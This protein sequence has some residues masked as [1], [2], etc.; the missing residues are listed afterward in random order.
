MHIFIGLV[1]T[2][3]YMIIIFKI[4]KTTPHLLTSLFIGWLLLLMPLLIEQ[5]MLG[6]GLAARLTPDPDKAR[7]ITFSYH[8]VFGLSLF[9]G[10]VIFHRIFILMTH[11]DS[12]K[13]SKKK[14]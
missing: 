11:L 12:S 4:L 8:T 1:D 14:S 5:P 10:S 3:I 2:Y 7:L 9:V 13:T 6:M